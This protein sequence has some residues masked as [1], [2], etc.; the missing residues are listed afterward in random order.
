M[1]CFSSVLQEQVRGV[2]EHT[3]EYIYI[4]NIYYMYVC[5]CVCVCVR[6]R[7][8]VCVCVCVCVSGCVSYKKVSRLKIVISAG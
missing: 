4:L 1:T 3:R 5:V 2:C 7:V 8:R 6:V